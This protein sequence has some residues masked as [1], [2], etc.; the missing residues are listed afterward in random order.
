[1]D[2]LTSEDYENLL[3]FRIGLRRFQRWSE[4][5][6]GEAGLTPAQHQLLLAIK[7]HR[8]QRPPTVGDLAGYLL[9]RHHSTVGL[10][11]RAEVAGLVERQ[12]DDRDGRVIRVRLTADGERHLGRLVSAHLDELQN[13]APVLDHVVAR[14][15][16][17]A[18][19]TARSP[20]GPVDDAGAGGDAACW[21]H[22]VCPEC[23]AIPDD[24]GHHK[25][26]PVAIGT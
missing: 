16:R 17:H 25:D 3:A 9:L 7:G 8:G 10:V 1:M 12:R 6:A 26:C 21:A 14:W 2:Q 22:L 13:L 23:G 5:Q 11:D 4:R 19:T 15:N 18:V 20:A 24:G